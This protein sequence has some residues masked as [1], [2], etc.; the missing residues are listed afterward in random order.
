[1]Q[2]VG[3]VGTRF[4]QEADPRVPFLFQVELNELYPMISLYF[5]Q[6]KIW[7]QKSQKNRVFLLK[8]WH[9]IRV[10]PA[11]IRLGSSS[12]RSNACSKY[13]STSS[14]HWYVQILY[15]SNYD[16]CDDRRRYRKYE[17][18]NLYYGESEHTSEQSSSSCTWDS[19]LSESMQELLESGAGI[20]TEKRFLGFF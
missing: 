18:P 3:E 19:F 5:P 9:P 17:N 7:S 12:R 20:L 16:F 10:I 11:S 15:S 13:S 6:S 8:F 14:I 2:D 1:M 4:A